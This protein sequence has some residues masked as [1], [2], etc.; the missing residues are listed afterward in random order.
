MLQRDN[1]TSQFYIRSY[2]NEQLKIISS[3]AGVS[4][5]ETY[6]IPLLISPDNL[7]KDNLPSDFKDIDRKTFDMVS[8]LDSEIL[9]IGTGQTQIFPDKEIFKFLPDY[10]YSTDFMDTGAACR[11]FNILVN[12]NRRV[13]ALLFLK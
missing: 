11:T 13:T 4:E 2:E 12:E 8:K 9:L 3:K 6:T 1:I 10:R 5:E 7:Q